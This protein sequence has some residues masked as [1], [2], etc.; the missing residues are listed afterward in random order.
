MAKKVDDTKLNKL[1]NLLPT[2]T[3]ME[4]HI[5]NIKERIA[6]PCDVLNI[7]M[8]GGIPVGRVAELSGHSSTGKSELLQI[9][10]ASFTDNN[11]I[12]F[13]YDVE[14]AYDFEYVSKK[15]KN[16]KNLRIICPESLAE[17]LKGIDT[18]IENSDGSIPIM[19][20]IDSVAALGVKGKVEDVTEKEYSKEAGIWS[21]WFR[22]Q[23]IPSR[24]VRKRITIVATNQSRKP[25]NAG[26]YL[27]KNDHT[28]FGGES[29]MFNCSVRLFAERGKK[30][31]KTINGIDKEIGFEMK[32]FS[33]KSRVEKPRIEFKIPFS[34]N[35]GIQN[36]LATLL[37]LVDNKI[38]TR[39]GKGYVY[40]EEKYQEKD[41][42]SRLDEDKEFKNEILTIIK[43]IL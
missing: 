28:T 42:F 32:L 21:K 17:A 36:N 7:Q 8:G 20:G 19:I 43:E 25:L 6:T 1:L 27:S 10:A 4:E 31:E 37:F 41:F 3:T 14:A 12:A 33:L 29:W 34:Y 5:A 39:E 16:I 18:I 30:I 13:I 24:I 22:D 2:A 40:K 15:F 38:V 9:M 11:G 23:M 26:M 35:G